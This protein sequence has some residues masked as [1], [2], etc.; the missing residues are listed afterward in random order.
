V[1]VP[2][3][4]NQVIGTPSPKGNNIKIGIVVEIG[5]HEK[6]PRS[7]RGISKIKEKQGGKAS[8]CCD[9]RRWICHRCIQGERV[10]G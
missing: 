6:K 1:I 4:P 5:G 7:L 9:I 10:M 2:Q 3:P 8:C